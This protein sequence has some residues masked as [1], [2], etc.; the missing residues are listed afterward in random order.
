M[1]EFKIKKIDDT[2]GFDCNACID[3]LS[4]TFPFRFHVFA[5]E[6]KPLFR[7]LKL[8]PS[9][10]TEL[11]YGLRN[12]KEGYLYREHIKIYT[13]GNENADGDETTNFLLSGDGCREIEFYGIDWFE[14]LSTIKEMGGLCKRIDTPIDDFS[15]VIT[16]KELFWKVVNREYS[17]NLKC[18]SNKVN[19][20]STLK[21]YF[22]VSQNEGFTF[23]LGGK[24]T[25][26]L[27]IYNKAAEKMSKNYLLNVQTWV[28][29]EAKWYGDTA[30]AIFKNVINA[31]R[32]GSFNRL[33]ASLMR[34]LI[35]FH[36]DIKYEGRNM[37]K[38]PI[39]K[40][41]EQLLQNVEKKPITSQL[42]KET[43]IATQKK[44][45]LSSVA[46]SFAR[47][48]LASFDLN[49]GERIE[50]S[51]AEEFKDK[52]NNKDLEIINKER[53]TNGLPVLSI[54]EATDILTLYI[55][56]AY[57]DVITGEVKKKG[58]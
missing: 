7:V 13:G 26:H 47:Q 16:L 6:F 38:N 41:W 1:G 39:W 56:S 43:T 32:D 21:N 20:P 4:I 5:D 15:G 54:K 27:T 33:I 28:R 55:N 25:K 29:Y 42:R 3:W 31:L 10:V 12:Y 14:F 50:T 37:Y 22:E 19:D 34:G 35:T 18:F 44:W 53:I 57:V 58:D 46:G 40:K 36:E 51:L 17:S 52:I 9:D 48:V 24:T 8:D 30:Q 45:L 23:D 2:D 49:T 11:G